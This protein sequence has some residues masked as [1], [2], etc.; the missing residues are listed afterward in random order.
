MRLALMTA[1]LVPTTR[2]ARINTTPTRMKAGHSF[3]PLKT[4]SP[5]AAKN[6]LHPKNTT[7][8]NPRN[9]DRGGYDGTVMK[10][11]AD[12]DNGIPAGA[13]LARE[14]DTNAGVSYKAPHD[15]KLYVYD[16]DSNRVI[17]SGT[18]RDGERF[19]IDSKDGRATIE[20]QSVLNNNRD[21]NPDHRYRLYVLAGSRDNVDTSR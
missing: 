10:Y 11:P 8:D 16:A 1:A 15:G 18:I 2:L 20:G 19:S 7:N 9:R 13:R 5:I 3:I 12:F 17:W 4:K 6:P 21:L 14:I